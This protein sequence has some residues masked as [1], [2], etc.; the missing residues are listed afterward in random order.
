VN[1]SFL[2]LDES[3]CEQ[4]TISSVTGILVPIEK[5]AAIRNG[6]YSK[7]RDVLSIPTNVIDIGIPDLH[8]CELLR[9]ESDEVKFSAFR[10]VVNLICVIR[11]H[12][13]N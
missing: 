8:G 11:R 2:F 1:T 10:A 7:L 5:Y 6:F 12:H 13:F 9:E 4:T 3:Y